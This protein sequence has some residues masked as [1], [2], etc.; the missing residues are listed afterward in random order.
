MRPS[1]EAAQGAGAESGNSADGQ[2]LAAVQPASGQGIGSRESR[3]R[4]GRSRGAD[5]L[6][7]SSLPHVSLAAV[8]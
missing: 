5:V 2:M 1:L 4:S 3:G 7:T 8:S 6:G